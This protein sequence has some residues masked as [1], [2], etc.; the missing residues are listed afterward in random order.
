[1]PKYFG[2]IKPSNRITEAYISWIG[3]N[4]MDSWDKF[5][6][7]NSHRYPLAEAI[8]A[9]EAIGYQCVELEIKIKK[10]D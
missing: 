9:Y 8:K 7:D 5:F 4:E 2:I 3:Q 6:I 1:M 10:N